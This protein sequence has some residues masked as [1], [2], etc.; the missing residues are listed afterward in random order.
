M[1]TAGDFQSHAATG[2]CDDRRA[3]GKVKTDHL[4]AP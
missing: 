3:I 4:C 2:A 1:N